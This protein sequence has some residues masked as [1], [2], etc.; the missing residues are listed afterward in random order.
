MTASWNGT[1]GEYLDLTRVLSRHCACELGLMGMRLSRC[2]AHN[3]TD[4]QRALDG[5]LFG[6][7]LAARL[8][9][10]EWLTRRRPTARAR[11]A[12]SSMAERAA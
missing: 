8:W 7:R 11:A 9:E 1:P 4:D 12:D 5:L 10:E 3:L 2:S 6:R